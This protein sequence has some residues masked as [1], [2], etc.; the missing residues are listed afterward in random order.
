[1]TENKPEIPK[2]VAIMR[3]GINLTNG[4]RNK[5]YG[6]PHP[7]LTTFAHLVNSYLKGLGWEGPKL[8]SVDGS[9]I[10]V[11]AK[12]SRVAVNKQHED[13]YVDGSTYFAIAGECAD[14][15]PVTECDEVVVKTKDRFYGMHVDKAVVDAE[16]PCPDFDA[17]PG[18]INVFT[19]KPDPTGCDACK[20]AVNHNYVEEMK[21]GHCGKVFPPQKRYD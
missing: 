4:D 11:L 9:M 1:M 8:D 2:R 16:W 6:S 20:H 10:M 12:V 21:C 13:N 15:I 14:E 7:N 3:Q 17:T 19:L 18:A 5:T